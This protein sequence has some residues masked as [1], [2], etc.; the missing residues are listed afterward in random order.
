MHVIQQKLLRLAETYNL[1]EMT[2]RDIG[3]LIGEEHP[4]TIKHHLEQLEKRTLIEWNREKKI[5]TKID[6]GVVVNRDFIII[7]ILGA[8]NCGDATVF[9][10]ERVEGHLK[11]STKLLKNKSEVFAVRAVG[12]SMNQANIDGK[13][14]EDG[15]YVLVDMEE[16]D[17]KNGDYVLS[18]IDDAANI[19]K[20]TFDKDHAQ[21]VLSSESSFPYPPI[22]LHTSEQSKYL[23]NGK[24]IQV[25][26]RAKS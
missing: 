5:I 4:Q 9:A 14:I 19:K 17:I 12:S 24:I 23:V 26:K 20:I 18:I 2:F 22:Y 7:P 10:E 6:K 3:K 13:T 11:I 25:V 8:A 16:K 1:G 21:V 15:D